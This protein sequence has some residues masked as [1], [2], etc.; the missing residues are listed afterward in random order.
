M[1]DTYIHVCLLITL[2][3]IKQEQTLTTLM[4]CTHDENECMPL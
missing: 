4:E 3:E 2:N 1:Y